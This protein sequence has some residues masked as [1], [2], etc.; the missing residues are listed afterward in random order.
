MSPRRP[1]WQL[2]TGDPGR[3]IQHFLQVRSIPTLT[4]RVY[5]YCIQLISPFSYPDNLLCSYVGTFSSSSLP[6][7]LLIVH[8]HPQSTDFG[9]G[10]IIE[11]CPAQGYLKC[12]GCQPVPLVCPFYR[13]PRH[14]PFNLRLNLHCK[15]GSFPLVCPVVGPGQA[16]LTKGKKGSHSG[17]TCKYVTIYF[18]LPSTSPH[19]DLL[20]CLRYGPS[21]VCNYVSPSLS[22]L[23]FYLNYTYYT[24]IPSRKAATSL[25]RSATKTAKLP[26]TASL[27]KHVHRLLPTLIV[28]RKRRVHA[29]RTGP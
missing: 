14:S 3:T 25:R 10:T 22:A 23:R 24:D 29:Q 7:V 11:G 27:L 21:I 13:L 8:V 6:S 18:V 19:L 12:P 1:S 26:R 28:S 4:H 20:H 17:I 16:L 9:G 5:R 2:P 15:A